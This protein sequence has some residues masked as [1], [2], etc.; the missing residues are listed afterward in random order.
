MIELRSDRLA[1]GESRYSLKN[2]KEWDENKHPR[3]KDGKF[4]KGG[5]SKEREDDK[6]KLEKSDIKESKTEEIKPQSEIPKPKIPQKMGQKFLEGI[7]SDIDGYGPIDDDDEYK[8]EAFDN[9]KR[10]LEKNGIEYI[11]AYHVTDM[12]S[13]EEGISGSS[14]DSTGGYGGN[15]RSKSVYMFF[16]PDD[17]PEGYQGIMGAHNPENTVMHIKIPLDKLKDFRWDSNYNVT[18]DTYSAVRMLGDV[19]SNWIDSMYKYKNKVDNAAPITV[20][21]H[22]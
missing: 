8:K 10:K 19:P 15:L 21:R 17:I 2:S 16:D 4:G 12:K 14:V 11:D 18:Y 13:S 22:A 9:I 1:R 7:L 6:P 3:A 20:Y 5:S